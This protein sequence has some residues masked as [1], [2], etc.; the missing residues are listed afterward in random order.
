MYTTAY[1]LVECPDGRAYITRSGEGVFLRS[2]NDG[3]IVGW[4]EGVACGPDGGLSLAAADRMNRARPL[5]LKN[6]HV[7]KR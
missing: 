3:D 2:R 7:T 5:D 1:Q 6:L 4:A